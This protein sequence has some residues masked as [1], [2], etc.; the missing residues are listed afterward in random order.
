MRFRKPTFIILIIIV[1]SLSLVL[2]ACAKDEAPAATDTSPDTTVTETPV[3]IV[4]AGNRP[5]ATIITLDQS[6]KER[7]IKVVLFPEYA[8]LTV[9]RFT[10]L[11]NVGHYDGSIFNRII[12]NFM[13]QGGGY[14]VEDGTLKSSNAAPLY[15]E[16]SE[17]GWTANT[18]L[19]KAGVISMARGN[20]NDS[21]SDQFF[22]CSVDY[23]SLNGKY[24]AFGTCLDSVS[25]QNVV[26]LS[27]SATRTVG[28]MENFPWPLVTIKSIRVA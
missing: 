1:L 25:L 5:V 2:S 13:I 3:I 6:G 8:P 11:A 4:E 19:H 24:A 15:G 7:T 18:L 12:S 17:N 28:G 9:T 27:Y 14:Y 16:F 20:D 22:I 23:P 10:E 21:A 26:D